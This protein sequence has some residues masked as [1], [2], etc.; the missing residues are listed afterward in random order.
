MAASQSLGRLGHCTSAL[1]GQ[2]SPSA[3]SHQCMP[4][5]P[6]RTT[7]TTTLPFLA[8]LPSLS[9]TLDCDSVAVPVAFFAC[10]VSAGVPLVVAR[11]MQQGPLLLGRLVTGVEAAVAAAAEGANFVLLQV[12]GQLQLLRAIRRPTGWQTRTFQTGMVA[13]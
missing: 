7:T 4:L 1:V 8:P 12:R 13:G 9:L 2:A 6:A 3:S 11:K 10:P 5:K